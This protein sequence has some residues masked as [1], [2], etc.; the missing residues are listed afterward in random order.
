M[1]A[2]YEERC[3]TSVSPE[4]CTEECKF[5]VH[6]AG[7]VRPVGSLPKLDLC[8]S[9]LCLLTVES[10][11]VGPELRS[12]YCLAYCVSDSRIGLGRTVTVTVAY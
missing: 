10:T 12:G 8:V 3:W 11:S 9:A 5:V 7:E 2:I 4:C 1:C 6:S